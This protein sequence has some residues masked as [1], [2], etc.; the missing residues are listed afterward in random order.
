MHSQNG[1]TPQRT[2]ANSRARDR[3]A[4][5]NGCKVQYC[6]CNSNVAAVAAAAAVLSAF[7][8]ALV[9]LCGAFLA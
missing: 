7:D 6:T 3:Y 1:R 2:H 9:W 4:K 8:V 5:C